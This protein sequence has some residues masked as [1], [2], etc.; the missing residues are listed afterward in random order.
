MPSGGRRD[1]AGRKHGAKDSLPRRG[2]RLEN[3]IELAK[4]E[5]NLI[6]PFKGDSKDLLTAVYRG[7]Y[8]ASREQ[9]FAASKVLLLEHPPAVT[10]DGRSVDE[11]RQQVRK[12]LEG[13]PEENRRK[14]HE[15]V[16]YFVR[17]SCIELAS[18]LA[19]Q[20]PGRSGC[21]AWVT[22]DV[23]GILKELEESGALNTRIS[24]IHP[25]A[26]ARPT[27]RKVP[28]SV[29]DAPADLPSEATADGNGQECSS[30]AEGPGAVSVSCAQ[31][32]PPTPPEPI[33]P[34]VWVPT[35]SPGGGMRLVPLRRN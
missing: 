10:S 3:A 1:G 21:P 24:E 25:P 31:K 12:E 23:D 30:K 22:E 29:I 17:A 13:D 6:Q 35:R 26:P 33:E 7:K 34:G 8:I 2:S 19:G 4:Y 27:F 32:P 18:R 20:A 11:I 9:I 16:A 28:E 15:L 5:Q 14:T